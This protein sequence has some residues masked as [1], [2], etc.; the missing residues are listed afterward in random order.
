MEK[1][2]RGKKEL[3]GWQTYPKLQKGMSIFWQQR[4]LLLLFVPA[5]VYFIVFHY[6]PLYGV[7][8]AFKDYQ[9]RKGILGSPWVGFAHFKHLFGLESF[10][11]VFRNTIVISL[12]KF[13]FGFPAPII[14]ALMLN[15]V[16]SNVLK[17]PIQTISY[18]PHFISWVVLGGILTQLLSPSTGPINLVISALGGDKIFF[19]ADS[20]WFRTVLVASSIWKNIGW[21][22]IIYLAALSSIDQELYE[23]AMIDGASR[24]QRIFKITIPQITPVITIMLILSTGS[25]INDDFDQVFNLYNSAVYDVGDV[26]STY[27]YRA[28]IVNFEY[29]L[30]T[31]IGLFKNLISVILVLTT[32]AICKRINDYAIY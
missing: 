11:Q 2:T 9:I 5:I 14:F 24:L 31:A 21:G 28:G 22:S 19:L 6:I 29:S 18:L 10:F 27:T 23:A 17:K 4:Y 12:L 13:I 1:K 26:L 25:L 8:I 15:E 3:A 32:N 30:A 7:T 20:Q 16:K